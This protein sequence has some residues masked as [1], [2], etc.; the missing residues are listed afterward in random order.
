VPNDVA[1][2]QLVSPSFLPI[3]ETVVETDLTNASNAGIVG[4]DQFTEANDDIS[5]GDSYLSNKQYVDAYGDYAAA[6]A[7]VRSDVSCGPNGC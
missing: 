4:P 3:E 2:M 1:A 7:I 5:G 6:Y